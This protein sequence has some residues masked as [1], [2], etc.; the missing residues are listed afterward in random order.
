MKYKLTNGYILEINYDEYY[1]CDYEFLTQTIAF[2]R[3]NANA[4]NPS[5]KSEYR[6]HDDI[7]DIMSE[8]D[9]YLKNECYTAPI[10]KCPT[11]GLYIS[12]WK[13]VEHVFGIAYI[14]KDV[15]KKEW[16]RHID[17]IEQATYDYMRGEFNTMQ[18]ILHGNVWC[19][20]IYDENGNVIDSCNGYVGDIETNGILDELS[21]EDKN[22]V[23]S[24][25]EMKEELC[26]K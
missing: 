18:D 1:V 4:I 24:G 6:M 2:G 22:T 3:N 23:L 16:G 26:I 12:D 14:P 13:T 19:F 25:K 21:E 10:S 5:S 7:K 11:S 20:K 8:N 17:D 9:G 15:A